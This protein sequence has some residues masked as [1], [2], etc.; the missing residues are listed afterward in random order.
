MFVQGGTR[1]Y[2]I[3]LINDERGSAVLCAWVCRI[4]SL[5]DLGREHEVDGGRGQ[6]R[7]HES[8]KGE[9]VKLI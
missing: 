6:R 5:D 8:H 9:N 7:R 3:A 1:D 2:V 4:V